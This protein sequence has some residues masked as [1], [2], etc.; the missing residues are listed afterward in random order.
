LSTGISGRCSTSFTRR[1]IAALAIA[2]VIRPIG[3][4][5]QKK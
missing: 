1:L 3:I 2:F 5:C 4:S